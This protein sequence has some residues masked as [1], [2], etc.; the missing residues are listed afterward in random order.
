M[1]NILRKFL[2]FLTLSLIYIIIVP[3]QAI[4]LQYLN[5]GVINKRWWKLHKKCVTRIGLFKLKFFAIRIYLAKISQNK[6][7]WIGKPLGLGLGLRLL[8]YYRS[9][10]MRNSV[11]LHIILALERPADRKCGKVVRP[12]NSCREQMSF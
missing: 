11:E 6:N 7:Q 2:N 8:R 4:F 10:D 9:N 12:T 3:T 5:F 1:V